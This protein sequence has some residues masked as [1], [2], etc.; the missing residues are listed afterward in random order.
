MSATLVL[1]ARCFYS[2]DALHRSIAF[3]H[4]GRSIWLSIAYC[5]SLRSHMELC[6][7]VSHRVR[8]RHMS[9]FDSFIQFC[10]QV[11]STP[12]LCWWYFGT[13][14]ST[15]NGIQEVVAYICQGSYY[16]YTSYGKAERFLWGGLFCLY[17]FSANISLEYTFERCRLLCPCRC[18]RS[19]WC[20]WT[21]FHSWRAYIKKTQSWAPYFWL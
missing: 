21:Y 19:L 13:N 1:S 3:S 6:I 7:Q 17:I 20:V 5:S 10:L 2:H 16:A 18:D 11:S 12:L 4:R 9:D 8:V 14:H 15:K